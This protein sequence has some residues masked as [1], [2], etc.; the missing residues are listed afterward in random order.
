MGWAPSVFLTVSIFFSQFSGYTMHIIYCPLFFIYQAV[1]DL[2]KQANQIC[3]TLLQLFEKIFEG[4]VWKDDYTTNNCGSTLLKHGY[5]IKSFRHCWAFFLHDIAGRLVPIDCHLKVY[6]N[7]CSILYIFFA[8]SNLYNF[9]F[10]SGMC[11]YL[12]SIVFYIL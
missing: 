2:R 3:D 4:A 10:M 7:N 1:C 8:G 5:M 11:N 9:D 6:W 12:M